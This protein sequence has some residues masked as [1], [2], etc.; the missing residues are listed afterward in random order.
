METITFY[1]YKGGTGR[2]LALAN[3]AHFL[4]RLGQKVCIMDFDFEAPGVHYKLPDFA[5]ISKG[6]L[7]DYIYDFDIRRYVSNSISDYAIKFPKSSDSQGEIILIPAG[8]ITSEDYWKKLAFINWQ[9]L[10]YELEFL[11]CWNEIIPE[12]DNSGLIEFLIK[13]YDITAKEIKKTSTNILKVITENN[14]ISLELDK[15]KTKVDLIIDDVRTD[16]LIVE[17]DKGKINVYK[18]VS[19]G[20]YF[21]LELKEMIEAELAP[22]FLLIDSRTG[23]TEMGGLC[24]SLLPDKVVMLMVNNKENIEGSKQIFNSLIKDERL[25]EQKKLEVIFALTRIPDEDRNRGREILKKLYGELGI[26]D[27]FILHSDRILELS[28]S[29]RSTYDDSENKQLYYEYLNLMS[30]IISN[31]FISN[32]EKALETEIF[33]NVDSTK[34]FLQMIKELKFRSLPSPYFDLE[35]YANIFSWEDIPGKDNG[36]FIEYFVGKYN[37]D[38]LKNAKIE[39]I[40]DGKAIKVFTK[41]NSISLRLN[42]EKTKVNVKIDD[43]EKDKLSAKMENSKL[44][45][46]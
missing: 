41:K 40:D 19:E 18:D 32:I 30:G 44:N 1:S 42:D 5:N 31:E 2:T 24:T 27:I 37:I 39:K 21:F 35:I 12:S 46:Y 15:N 23:I 17:M 16:E 22:D 25:P 34:G 11:F 8:D 4:S 3:I 38:W 45:I 43:F 7:L 13:Y 9:R 33:H 6:G 26:Q 29:L 10:F 28:E 14:S 36:K 20:I